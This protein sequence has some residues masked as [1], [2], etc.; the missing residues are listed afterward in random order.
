MAAYRSGDI[1][2]NEWDGTTH[3][4]SKRAELNTRKSPLTPNAPD[5]FKD[6]SALWNAVKKAEKSGNAQLDRVIEIAFAVELGPNEQRQR[7]RPLTA[8]KTLWVYT[9]C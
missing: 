7:V 3:D 6:C 9:L 2:T 1:L 4:Y 5:T 8:W